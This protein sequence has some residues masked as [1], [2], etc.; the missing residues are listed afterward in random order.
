MQIIMEIQM[1]NFRIEANT[2]IKRN[3]RTGNRMSNLLTAQILQ[4]R[5]VKTQ[6]LHQ[7]SSMTRR[8]CSSDLNSFWRSKKKKRAV[9]LPAR[10]KTSKYKSCT[11]SFKLLLQTLLIRFRKSM[12]RWC[13][14]SSSWQFI[15]THSSRSMRQS[16]NKWS[17]FKI[18]RKWNICHIWRTACNRIMSALCLRGKL[19]TSLSIVS[20]RSS[21]SSK[22]PSIANWKISRSRLSGKIGSMLKRLS[23]PRDSPQKQIKLKSN[24]RSLKRNRILKRLPPKRRLIKKH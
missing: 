8:T 11:Q 24:K 2:T 17:K 4:V 5:Q 9:T 16:S 13:W 20:M 12:N 6:M 23:W 21:L 15:R 3:S 22:N 18:K 19:S 10:A 7:T 14:A 1:P